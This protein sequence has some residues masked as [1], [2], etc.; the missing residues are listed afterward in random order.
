MGAPARWIAGRAAAGPAWLYRFAYVPDGLRAS[1]PGAGH[2]SEIP[3]VFDSWDHLGALGKGLK[4]SDEDRAMTAL[5][6]S[7][8]VS[9]AKTGAPVCAGAPAWPPYTR[10]AD[11]LMNFDA[12][13]TPKSGF[14]EARYDAQ[15]A[16]MLPTLDLGK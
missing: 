6:H 15:E 8:W 13:A 3:F 9:F 7:C 4:L 16:A 11:T 10:S 12:E 14:N 5:V 1:V 2:D